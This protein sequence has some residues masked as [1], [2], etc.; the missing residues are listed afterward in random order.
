MRSRQEVCRSSACVALSWAHLAA[1]RSFCSVPVALSRSRTSRSNAATAAALLRAR[2][3]SR[4]RSALLGDPGTAA[5]GAGGR[6]F[7]APTSGPSRC[8]PRA[9][10][11]WPSAATR[12]ARDSLSSCRRGLR[13]GSVGTGLA[14][15]SSA[16]PRSAPRS[17]VRC[18]HSRSSP[19]K[20]ARVSAASAPW[21]EVS[22]GPR[23]PEAV[24]APDP[25]SSASRA[26]SRAT[27][28]VFATS[29]CC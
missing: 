15:V 27:S 4:M 28:A 6:D 18:C 25:L 11:A 23:A 29:S 19:R 24:L 17:G 5:A 14:A 22:S 1:A 26:L 9:A 3:A 13:P 12:P 20:D 21:P 10:S 2:P 7:A 16:K 8:A